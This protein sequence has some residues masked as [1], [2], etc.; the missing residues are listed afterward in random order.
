MVGMGYRSRNT[1][2]FTC[3]MSTQARMSPL[4]FRMTTMKGETQGSDCLEYIKSSEFFEL[5]RN[6]LAYVERDST[7]GLGNRF[8]VGI[9]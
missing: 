7:S 9:D 3:R 2:V 6:L 4:D 1:A 5:G 8:Y